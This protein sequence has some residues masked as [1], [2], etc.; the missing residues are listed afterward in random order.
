MGK[1][2]ATEQQ[3]PAPQCVAVPEPGHSGARSLAWYINSEPAPVG[4]ETPLRALWEEWIKLMS[5]AD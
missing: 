5:R 2:L 4:G 3:Q 1:A